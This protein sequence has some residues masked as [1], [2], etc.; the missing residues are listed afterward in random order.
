MSINA[1]LYSKEEENYYI[2]QATI[3]GV[4]HI[5]AM[6][7]RYIDDVDFSY[8]TSSQEITESWATLIANPAKKGWTKQDVTLEYNNS[9]GLINNYKIVKS[10]KPTL[11]A[12]HSYVDYEGTYLVGVYSSIE[13]AIAVVQTG[14]KDE[15]SCWINGYHITPLKIDSFAKNDD[16]IHLNVD[17]SIKE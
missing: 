9:R 6:C 1:T 17:G 4:Y 12:L 15:M 2:V 7:S 5:A 13:S 16:I 14:E 3:D 11:F 10:N 8:L